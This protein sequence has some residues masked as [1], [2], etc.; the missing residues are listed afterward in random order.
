MSDQT[1]T[2]EEEVKVEAATTEEVAEETEVKD[3]V[4]EEVSELEVAQ[5][6]ATE[7]KEK[8]FYIAAEMENLKRR[9]A[10]EMDKVRKFGSEK[11]L[12]SML[13]IVDNLERTLTAIESDEDEKVKNI[14]V[15]I[16]M[17]RNQFMA[18]LKDN[19]LEPVE[20]VGKK[21]DPNF[22]EA[23]TQQPAEGKEDDEIITEFQK[24][25]MLNGRLLRA[26]KVVIVKN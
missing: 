4:V 15:G 10:N 20:A 9:Q 18:S 13:D 26:A 17:V 24:G 2:T 3:E 11:L 5:K 7:M 6:E 23:M 14:F 19:G 21:F 12:K 8:Y 1:Q 22:H 16:D 25:Y